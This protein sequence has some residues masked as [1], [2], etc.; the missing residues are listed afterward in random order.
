M[1]DNFLKYG[2]VGKEINNSIDLREAI[3]TRDDKKGTKVFKIKSPHSKLTLKAADQNERNLWYEALTR[4]AKTYEGEDVS[5][6]V[7]GMMDE[8][9]ICEKKVLNKVRTVKSVTLN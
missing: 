1:Q 7:N 8:N 4:I 2:K 3:V 5:K 6:R 9:K